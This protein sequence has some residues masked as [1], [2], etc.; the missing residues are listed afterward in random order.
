MMFKKLKKRFAP[1][2]KNLP[3]EPYDIRYMY[4]AGNSYRIRRQYP[5]MHYIGKFAGELSQ[6]TYIHETSKP[7]SG[8][9]RYYS[10]L[11]KLMIQLHKL[12]NAN[13]S[14]VELEQ[15]LGHP[16]Y[17]QLFTQ[18]KNSFSNKTFIEEATL[19]E[20][21]ADPRFTKTIEVYLDQIDQLTQLIVDSKINSLVDT[22][23]G[24]GRNTFSKIEPIEYPTQNDNVLTNLEYL[25][26]PTKRSVKS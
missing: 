5:N 1:K 10:A 3:T 22:I 15:L 16:A 17:V 4:G 23:A 24:L 26:E 8:L 12:G 13:K 20:E 6:Y 11:M 25:G 14:L 18:L 21:S 7:T 9:M 2:W 19:A